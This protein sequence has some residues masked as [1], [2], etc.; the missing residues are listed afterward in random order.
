MFSYLPE[1][2][3]T[4]QPENTAALSSLASLKTAQQ[5]GTILEARA[6][7]CDTSHNLIVDLGYTRGIIPYTE[8][9]I[10][11]SEGTT[12]DIAIISRVNKPV[13]FKVIDFWNEG[14]EVRPVLSRRAAQ[15]ECLDRYIDSLVPGQVIPARVTH[16]EPF[17]CFADVGC[18][19]AAL[20]P[21]DAISVSR[22][23]HPSDRFY[24]GQDI[25]AVV[26]SVDSARRVLLSHKELLGTW[27]QNAELFCPGETVAGVVRSILDAGMFIELTPNLVGLATP[28]AGVREGQHASVYIKSFMPEKMKVKLAVVETFDAQYTP[29]LSKYFIDSGV[30]ERW[31]YSPPGAD[32][33]IES[34]F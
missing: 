28:R 16:L 33:L 32:R 25:K 15:Q 11:I 2:C 26:R 1:G 17:G 24:V 27:E 23:S 19:L 22:I 29:E 10:G 12:K 5:K 20:L 3:R 31:Q 8:G 18:G 6:I 7:V 13:C 34:V 30:I 21:I 9:A 4:G 14:E